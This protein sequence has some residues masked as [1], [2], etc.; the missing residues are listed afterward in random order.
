MSTRSTSNVRSM[1]Q[2]LND[3]AAAPLPGFWAKPVYQTSIGFNRHHAPGRLT[4]RCDQTATCG[5]SPPCAAKAWVY[6]GSAGG[7]PFDRR[8]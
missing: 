2:A 7:S 4:L 1:Q 8:A 6:G 3:L 5:S